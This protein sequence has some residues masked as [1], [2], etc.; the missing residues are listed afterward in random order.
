MRV[1]G[2]VL[3]CIASLLV[4]VDDFKGFFWIMTS[5]LSFSAFS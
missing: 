5:F 4:L 1:R 3:V 2:C